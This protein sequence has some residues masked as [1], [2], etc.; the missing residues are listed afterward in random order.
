MLVLWFLQIF[1]LNNYYQEMKINE[2]NR[3]ATSVTAAYNQMDAEEFWRRVYD[4]TDTSDVYI[5]VEANSIPLPGPELEGTYWQKVF[6]Y[7]SEINAVKEQ[8]YKSSG[9]SVSVIL[10][11][12][13]TNTNTLAYAGYLDNRDS[14]NEVILYIFS[15]LYPVES[16]VDIL[17]QQLVYVTIISVVLAF[18]LSFYLSN[19]ISK[20]I[21]DINN[22]AKKLASGKYGIVFQ[23]GHYT[24][25]INLADTLTHT[26][27][28][29]ER[30][31]CLQKDLMANVS[32]DLR[33]PLTMVKSYAEMIRDISGDV[34]EKRNA[35]LQVIIDEADRLN[36]L[37]NDMLTLSR[38]QSGVLEL[39]KA[40]FSMRE[41]ADAI[42]QSY[43]ILM[44][45]EGYSILL[46]CPEDLIVNGDAA[47][48]KQV[49]SNLLNNAVK[50][51]GSN[52]TIFLSIRRVKSKMR[53]EVTDQG[54]GIEPEELSQIWDRY[55]K[56]STNHVRTTTGT[57]L[58]LSIVKE[59][60]TLH[61][62]KF[63][64]ESEVGKGSTF[65]FELPLVR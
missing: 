17:Q 62:A 61:N 11:E 47:K 6:S 21:K 37:V 52:K 28:Q 10:S 29:L 57:G 51:C 43:T 4:F 64:V 42:L 3:I 12:T 15:P 35:H 34:P 32:H 18:L 65:W 5:R 2:T 50:Y 7:K 45:Q 33:T 20:P 39:Q 40:D 16:T 55:Y 14:S 25:I 59:I 56:A 49:L 23:G 38:M 36:R 27:L 41:V 54:M 30:A 13:R 8:L 22:Q 46:D 1:F 24:E 63:G 9:R 44:E 48:L 53:C 19:R 58:G 26:S 31:S 60:L